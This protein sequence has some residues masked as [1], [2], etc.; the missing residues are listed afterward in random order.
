MVVNEWGEETN[1]HPDAVRLVV[2]VWSPGNTSKNRRDKVA[3]FAAAGIPFLRSV[4]FGPW[5]ECRFAAHALVHGRYVPEV[6]AKP[7]ERV[8]VTASPLPV[9]FDPA[10]LSP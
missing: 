8:T 5:G 9:T 7:G 2:E 1:T 6:E 3:A 10:D 4:E